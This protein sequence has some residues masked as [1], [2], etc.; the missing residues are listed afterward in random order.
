[1]W[2]IKYKNIHL[3]RSASTES[4]FQMAFSS[5]HLNHAHFVTPSFTQSL[6]KLSASLYA[7]FSLAHKHKHKD[8]RTRRMAYLPQISIPA[9]LNPI[10]K[11]IAD[12]SS[13]ILLLICSHEVW[14]KVAYDWTTALCLSLC[15][16]RPRFHQSKGNVDK[17]IEIK[18]RTSVNT[19]AILNFW[20]QSRGLF[21]L[22]DSS[23]FNPQVA[24]NKR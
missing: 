1:M 12:T 4:V 18:S 6:K 22:E 8:I 15:L 2:I 14:V 21:Q 10:I 13:A 17:G 24:V 11:K 7:W 3:F 16:C 9:L 5:K 20:K 23:S 19:Q